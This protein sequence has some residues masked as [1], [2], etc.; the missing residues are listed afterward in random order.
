MKFYWRLIFKNI[1]GLSLI[2]LVT[3]G[4]PF[5]YLPFVIDSVGIKLYGSLAIQ[6]S[7]YLL[8]A[9]ATQF[10]FNTLGTKSILEAKGEIKSITSNLMASKIFLAFIIT[11]LVLLASLFIEPISSLHIIYAFLF[12]FSE[13]LN[14][15]WY[16]HGLNRLSQ[17]SF[18]VVFERFSTCVFIVLSALFD[19][20]IELYFFSIIIPRTCVHIWIGMRIIQV[21]YNQIDVLKM[22]N[23]FKRSL[24]YF[25]SRFITTAVDRSLVILAGVFVGTAQAGQLDI[26][27]KIVGVLQIPSNV[28]CQTLFSAWYGKN[29]KKILFFCICLSVG[30][31]ILLALLKGYW[32]YVANHFGMIPHDSLLI[33]EILYWAIIINIFSH[34]IG[35]HFVLAAGRE[36][37]FNGSVIFGALLACLLGLTIGIN[38]GVS[39]RL[40]LATYL[41]FLFATLVGR[42]SSIMLV[43]RR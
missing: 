8:A 29:K 33:F 36:N 37:W 27:Q 34:N 25:G 15:R 19:L 30:Y 35:Y 17:L 2:E 38:N 26:V 16:F 14:P 10:G 5:V 4:F 9:S 40:V 24:G 31:L 6:H 13:A 18:Y 23:F 28:I 32:I 7:Y 11:T 43:W 39:I 1:S 41:V 42:V 3:V 20:V 12:C 22:I 21:E